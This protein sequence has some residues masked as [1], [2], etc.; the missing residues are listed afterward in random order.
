MHLESCSYLASG[1]CGC[2]QLSCSTQTLSSLSVSLITIKAGYTLFC[3][4][5]RMNHSWYKINLGHWYWR[6]FIPKIKPVL[7]DLPYKCMLS[8]KN[9]TQSDSLLIRAKKKVFIKNVRQLLPILLIVLATTRPHEWVVAETMIKAK[10][11]ILL[12]LVSCGLQTL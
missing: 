3:V 7:P 9:R 12:I 5:G 6:I 2:R 4:G 8:L 10:E 1:G 11:P